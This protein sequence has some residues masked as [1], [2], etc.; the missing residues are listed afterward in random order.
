MKFRSAAMKNIGEPERL[1]QPLKL[2]S[3]PS[4]LVTC[5]LLLAV[6]GVTVWAVTGT[7]A[8]TVEAEGVLTRTAG[9][10]D[11][12]AGVSGRVEQ[13][14][15]EPADQVSHG[16]RLYTVVTADGEVQHEPAPW[17]AYVVNLLV[18]EGQMLDPGTPTAALERVDGPGDELQARLYVP[19]AQAPMLHQGAPV[20][21]EVESA[22]PAAFGTVG[23]T[24]TSVGRFPETAASLLAFLGR[25][26][27]IDRYLDRGPP[28]AVTVALDRNDS[29]EL[30]WSKSRPPF[31]VMSQSSV[32]AT[33]TLAEERPIDW[34]IRRW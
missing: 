30:V 7:V 11:F 17:D 21:I 5:A 22:A 19:A 10:T 26:R 1:D 4:W 9:V 31:T 34:V 20:E 13:V 15:V 18:T 3:I 33:F 14:W 2:S 25:D 8:R 12:E 16:D 27:S 29:G 28:I 24:V 23:G 6:V 32:A